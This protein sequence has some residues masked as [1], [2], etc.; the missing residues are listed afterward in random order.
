MFLTCHLNDS[1]VKDNASSWNMAIAFKKTRTRHSSTQTE[2]VYE[3][4]MPTT[5]FVELFV[6]LWYGTI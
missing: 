1:L 3:N 5:S 6:P 2:E 4:T